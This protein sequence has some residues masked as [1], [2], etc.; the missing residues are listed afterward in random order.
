MTKSDRIDITWQLLADAHPRF[1]VN[2]R[3]RSLASSLLVE[4]DNENELVGQDY[5]T[6]K[7]F[8]ER[9]LLLTDAELVKEFQK[10]STRKQAE[11]E[12][13]H[14]FNQPEALA[15]DNIIEF[16]SRAELWTLGEAAALING[17]N[18]A[19]I[20]EDAI[21]DNHSEIKIVVALKE[22]LV[23]LER[24]RLA[25][26][27]YRTNS[28]KALISWLELKHIK[29]PQKLKDLAL[30]RSA[31]PFTVAA[32]NG[33]LKEKLAALEAKPASIETADDSIKVE[34]PIG[35]RE[36]ESLLKLILGMAIIGYSYDP[37]SA[38]SREISEIASDLQIAGLA[39]DPDTVRK[40]LDEA[41]ALF[42][43]DINR[44]E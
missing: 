26:I 19:V 28:P 31:T 44:T 1:C 12:A 38:K 43:D 2:V 7:A 24:A 20:T 25:G 37:K 6:A 22:T 14:Y 18:P 11:I 32:E 29:I 42:S 41:K 30:L 9:L 8:F 33:R 39:L 13:K 5:Q 35:T 16:W 17:R 21:E 23:L 10:L 4:P 34:K 15:T 3:S 27:L 36:R 40:Y